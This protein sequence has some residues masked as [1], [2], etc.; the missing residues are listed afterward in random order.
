VTADV[1]E[2]IVPHRIAAMVDAREP[3]RRR[4]RSDTTPGIHRRNPPPHV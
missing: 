4:F 2:I 1:R 3:A